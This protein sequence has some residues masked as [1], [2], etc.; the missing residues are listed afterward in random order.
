MPF[1]AKC[2]FALGPQ[3]RF[4]PRCG[5]KPEAVDPTGPSQVGRVEPVGQMS[6]AN[7][8]AG[9]VAMLAGMCLLFGGCIY[10]LAAVGS[11]SR[12]GSTFGAFMI[13]L[14]IALYIGGRF[15]HWWHWE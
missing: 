14:G 1:C 5:T 9:K 7:P 8:R 2:G 6:I 13:L 3:H 10:L 11:G 12:G 4:C 15:Q